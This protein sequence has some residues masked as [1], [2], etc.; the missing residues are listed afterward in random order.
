MA[1]EHLPI[2]IGLPRESAWEMEEYPSSRY[3]AFVCGDELPDPADAFDALGESFGVAPQD[4]APLPTEADEV[5]WAFRCRIPSRTSPILVWCERVGAADVPDGEIAD[6]RW[7]ILVEALFELA[8]PLLDAARLGAVVAR[9]G[10]ARTRLMLNPDLGVVYRVDEIKRLFLAKRAGE[11]LDERHLFRVEIGARDRANGPFWLTTV[12]LH[13]V[14]RPEMEMLEIPA[15]ELHAALAMVDAIAARFVSTPLPAAGVPFEAG[16]DLS[17]ALVP[18]D[19]VIETISPDMP[20]GPSDR[21]RMPRAPRAAICAAGRRGA[22]RPVW[23]PPHE[24]LQKLTRGESGLLRSERETEVQER[25]AR[26]EWPAFLSAFASRSQYPMRHYY[27]K[28]A[29]TRADEIV[30]EVVD[31]VVDKVVEHVWLEVVEASEDSVRGRRL[32]VDRLRAVAADVSTT[33]A[34]GSLVTAPIA[35]LS[36]WVVTGVTTPRS[37]SP[38]EVGPQAASI[39]TT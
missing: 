25:L 11:F 18:V 33:S 8:D 27:A 21:G 23:V 16:A 12:G 30:D 29:E 4:I 20:G 38:I 39:L 34:V 10:G 9:A 24:V 35:R 5:Q 22:F 1:R 17:V 26:L 3:V 28:I 13:R 14:A 36:D 15:D 2:Q 19:E 7:S 6:A 37:A 32:E 31:K